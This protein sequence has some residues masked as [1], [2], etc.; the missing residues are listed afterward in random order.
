[1]KKAIITITILIPVIA[2]LAYVFFVY[3]DYTQQT[4]LLIETQRQELEDT[5]TQVELLA[6][7]ARNYKKQ[8]EAMQKTISTKVS[9][10]SINISAIELY[11]YQSA[12]VKIS[13]KDAQGSGTLWYSPSYGYGVLTN[14]HVMS[15]PQ[16]RESGLLPQKRFCG[17]TVTG[18]DSTV[19]LGTYW[20][21]FDNQRDWNDYTDT[22]F[23]SIEFDADMKKAIES[24]DPTF[25]QTPISELNYGLASMKYC[26]N[27]IK[28]G[29]PVSIIGY[30]SFS[31]K[32]VQVPD[33][34][35]YVNES[36]RTIT[37]GVISARDTSG[38]SPYGNLPYSNYYVSAKIDS[39][40]SG[41]IAISKDEKG[42]C[43]L[44]LPTWLNV[45]SYDTQGLVQNINNIMSK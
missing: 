39:G 30:P 35:I 18:S 20:I 32:R 25:H 36:A 6:S 24:L 33:R 42:L 28:T 9:V 16:I 2:G 8:Q 11:N 12:V 13:C 29:S 44:G 19:A 5:K 38:M 40:N 7:E 3:K 15:M 17:L 43:V 41:G 34:D 37:N 21:N 27:N 1:M 26:S 22:S 14:D 23:A 4:D 10:E 31:Q 45:G